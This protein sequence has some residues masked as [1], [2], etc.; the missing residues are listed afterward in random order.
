MEWKTIWNLQIST[1]S[2]EN[3][4][5]QWKLKKMEIVWNSVK[6]EEILTFFKKKL[7]KI[8]NSYGKSL[9]ITEN[10]IFHWKIFFQQKKLK[11]IGHQLNPI[12]TTEFQ[13]KSVI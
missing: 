3:R 7:L 11:N 9:K 8:T 13:R 6:K 12:E 5:F 1:K 2:T 4:G 10:L